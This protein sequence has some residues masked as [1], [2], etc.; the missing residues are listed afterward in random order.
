MAWVKADTTT[1][2]KIPEKHIIEFLEVLGSVGDG[3]TPIELLMYLGIISSIR[4][5][6]MGI[7]T[8]LQHKIGDYRVD[9]MLRSEWLDLSI[10]IECDGHDFH[11]KTKEQAARDKKRD[12]YLQ[13][14][15]FKVF[16]F[17]GSEIWKDP[18]T[19]AQEIVAEF[20]FAEMKKTRTGAYAQD[21]I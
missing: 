6:Y 7:E 13:S 8:N 5:G 18:F 17:S 9:F 14:M 4:D 19:C 20:E 15:G 11:E 2:G 1:I 21:K 16:R 10:V 3:L 12:R